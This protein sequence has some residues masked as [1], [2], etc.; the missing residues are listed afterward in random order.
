M[1]TRHLLKS[2]SV[3]LSLIVVAFSLS[4]SVFAARSDTA[5]PTYSHPA[6]ISASPYQDSKNEL[7]RPYTEWKMAD[8][9][10]EISSD[11]TITSGNVI[12]TGEINI[13]E[14]HTLTISG[15]SLRLWG[16]D[17]RLTG[18][19]VVSGEGELDVWGGA[20]EGKVTVNASSLTLDKDGRTLPLPN[21]GMYNGASISEVNISAGYMLAENSSVSS[22]TISGG[23]LDLENGSKLGKLFLSGAARMNV[24]STASAESVSLSSATGSGISIYCDGSISTLTMSSGTV[25]LSGS[26]GTLN[27]D[28][29]EIYGIDSGTISAVV[30]SNDG[31]EFQDISVGT[32]IVPV[33][34]SVPASA[35]THRITINGAVVDPDAYLIDGSNY[36]K[37]R[38]I[39]YLLSNST[40]RFNVGFDN[41]LKAVYLFPGEAYQPVGGE[42]GH[43]SS[44][45][46]SAEPSGW[47]VF[48]GGQQLNVTVY[49]ING[50]NYFK[51]RDLG[52]ALG[53]GVSFD[54]ATRTVLVNTGTGYTES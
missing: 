34:E 18:N 47:H 38:D 2:F 9:I 41:V 17:A 33:T 29:G 40:K 6:G 46:I 32:I 22:A 35:S 8:G 24:R 31:Y 27:F 54:E 53:F 36:F 15:G 1:S 12:V 23:K 7:S 4:G 39:A 45:S 51:L 5:A 50:N 43:P 49:N 3:F 16:T 10:D 26:I 14:G 37:L 13:A 11:Y 42:L 25:E 52:A 44:S 20:V 48:S 28:G 30:T 21:L 19:V